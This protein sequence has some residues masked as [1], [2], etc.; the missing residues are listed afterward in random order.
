MIEE[1]E[2]FI[3]RFRYKATKAVQVQS[4]I[5]Q[6]EKLER[7]EMEE[8]DIAGFR[9]H[10]PPAPRSG[11]VV[12]EAKNVTKYYDF[13][14]VLNDI[15]LI[16]ERGEKVAFVGRNGEGK[17]TLVRAILNEI[18]YQGKITLGHNV[19]I[20][21]FAQNQEQKLNENLTVY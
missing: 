1:T 4:R 19:K 11:K 15:H 21:Y 17:T 14:R 12:M 3:E 8:A 16:L 20:G 2:R 18:S 9:I 6:L 7:I 10:F 5:K 13:H